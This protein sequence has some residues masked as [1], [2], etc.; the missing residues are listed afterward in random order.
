MELWGEAPTYS[1]K[2]KLSETIAPHVNFVLSAKDEL[3]ERLVC[4]FSVEKG[5]GEPDGDVE[6][7][8]RKLPIRETAIEDVLVSMLGWVKVQLDRLIQKGAPAVIRQQDFHKAL[9]ACV[10]KIDRPGTVLPARA[11]IP[12]RKALEAEL[13]RMYVQQL[14]IIESDDEQVE[15]AIN[16]CLR[17]AAERTAWSAAGD[18]FEDSFADFEDRLCRSWENQRQLTRVELKG[19]DPVEVGTALLARCLQVRERLQG[20]DT[21]SHFT[22]GS[23]HS[24]ADVPHV[25]WHPDYKD[26]LTRLA[27]GSPT[28]MVLPDSTAGEA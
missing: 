11:P 22:P 10:H 15:R 19:R 18:V 16:D 12:E 6:K 13:G 2:P 24:L 21:P 8:L 5:S 4:S 25:G 14:R 20:M 3:L 26:E 7:E 1:E 27:R 28:S 17:A 23:F 9:I